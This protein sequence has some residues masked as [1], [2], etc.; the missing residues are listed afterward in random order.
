V[1]GRATENIVSTNKEYTMRKTILLS[2]LALLLVPALAVSET[3]APAPAV[4]SQGCDPG[5]SFL[6][7]VP[8][9]PATGDLQAVSPLAKAGQAGR[10][11][12]KGRRIACEAVCSPC[13]GVFEFNCDPAT[14]Q[15]SC[16][17]NLCP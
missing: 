14:C 3:Q 12:C 8:M 9:T 5:L 1:C 11:C 15:A 4:A 17:C 2:L 6:G 16:I 7:A 13:G 10:A